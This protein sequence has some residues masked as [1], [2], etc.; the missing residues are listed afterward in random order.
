MTATKFHV[1]TLPV[2]VYSFL[3]PH[4]RLLRVTRIV[5]QGAGPIWLNS[6][7][8][9]LQ[10]AKTFIEWLLL[11]FQLQMYIGRLFEPIVQLIIFA[12]LGIA[13]GCVL[14]CKAIKS[15]FRVKVSRYNA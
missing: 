9:W 6:L 11:P 2:N 5:V 12:N 4:P 14:Y 8:D 3:E 15:F 7:L 13:G 1:T 10:V